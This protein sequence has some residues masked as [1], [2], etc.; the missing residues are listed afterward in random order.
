MDARDFYN[1]ALEITLRNPPAGPAWCR[2]AIG[3]AYYAT[4]IV[5]VDSLETA[6][7]KVA[8]GPDKHIDV[9]RCLHQSGDSQPR[10]AAATLD[11]LKTERH[12]A[13]YEMKRS[14]VETISHARRAVQD[15]KDILAW[16]DAFVKDPVRLTAAKASIQAYKLKTNAP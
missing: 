3:R 15:A 10:T 4:L 9:S 6:G 1:V 13:D 14:D 5:A 12:R 8:S 11:A 16:L 7:V 2:T